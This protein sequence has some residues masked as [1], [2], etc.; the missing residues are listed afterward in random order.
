MFPPVVLYDTY[1]YNH[2]FHSHPYLILT[3]PSISVNH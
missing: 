1:T 2:I 3:S